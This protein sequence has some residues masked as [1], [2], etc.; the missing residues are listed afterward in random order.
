[1]AYFTFMVAELGS[2]PNGDGDLSARHHS[3]EDENGPHS[4]RAQD[5]DYEG[6]PPGRDLRGAWKVRG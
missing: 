2:N 5:H 1:M 6:Q 3:F 4:R